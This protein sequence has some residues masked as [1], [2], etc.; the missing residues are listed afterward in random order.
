MDVLKTIVGKHLN[1]MFL[2]NVALNVAGFLEMSTV[3]RFQKELKN[4]L[5]FKFYQTLEA[6]EL[7][8]KRPPFPKYQKNL[9]LCTEGV[10]SY[11]TEVIELD[12]LRRTMKLL[13]RWSRTTSR[14]QNY[15]L[16]TLKADWEFRE[17][18][19]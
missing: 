5:G 4:L 18:K 8:G 1:N 17:I 3:E 19:D 2:E 14:H 10:Y 12:W 9:R 6:Y 16:K 11:G 7:K 13:G 15:A